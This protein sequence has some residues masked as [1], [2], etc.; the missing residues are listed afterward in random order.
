MTAASYCH[1]MRISPEIVERLVD[2]RTDAT[3]EVQ[4]EL[5]PPAVDAVEAEELRAANAP[6]TRQ[7]QPLRG[8]ARRGR[9]TGQATL[10]NLHNPIP[11]RFKSGRP[12]CPLSAGTVQPLADDIDGSA[13]V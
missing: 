9:A 13:T 12:R 10:R 7:H 11:G 4:P 3:A 1:V 6:N 5:R 2:P 8:T